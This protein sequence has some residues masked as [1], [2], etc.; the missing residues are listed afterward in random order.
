MPLTIEDKMEIQELMGRY[1]RASDV[2]GPEALRDIFTED[3]RFVI[4]AMQIEVT[5][6]DNIIAMVVEFE[7][8]LPSKI[9]HFSTNFVIDGDGDQATLTCISQA[10]QPTEDGIKNFTFGH[11]EDML[12]K[13]PAGWRLKDHKIVV[14]A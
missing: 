12:V 8:S 11:Y 14:L 6:V 2:D 10:V 13:T 5:G 9:Y 1:I 3:A 7:K 4:D